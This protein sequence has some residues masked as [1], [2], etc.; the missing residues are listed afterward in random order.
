M[1]IWEFTEQS[2][3]DLDSIIEHCEALQELG[4]EQ[5]EDMMAELRAE[6][7]KREEEAY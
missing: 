4:I 3:E 7:R 6:Q 2:N 1:G 5:D